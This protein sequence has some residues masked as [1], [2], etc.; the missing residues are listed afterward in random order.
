MPIPSTGRCRQRKSGA[1]KLE[2]GSAGNGNVAHSPSP[3]ETRR[4]NQRATSAGRSEPMERTDPDLTKAK[5]WNGWNGW[6]RL[7]PQIRTI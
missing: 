6:N 4:V 5:C 2:G 1:K 3:A 7:Q